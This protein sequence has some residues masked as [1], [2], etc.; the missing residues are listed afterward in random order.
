MSE[1]LW[2]IGSATYS[3]VIEFLERIRHVHLLR[4]K[5][6]TI[7]VLKAQLE[8]QEQDVRK[9]GRPCDDLAMARASAAIAG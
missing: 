1:F 9:E 2:Q 5:E 6:A 7:R 8:A 4:A 3:N